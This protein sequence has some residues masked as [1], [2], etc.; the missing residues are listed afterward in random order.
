MDRRRLQFV[1]LGVLEMFSVG[2][3]E[4]AGQY[5]REGRDSIAIVQCEERLGILFL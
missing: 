2:E 4:L 1:C 5:R 3:E